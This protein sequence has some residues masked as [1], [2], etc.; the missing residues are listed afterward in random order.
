MAEPLRIALAGVGT[1]GAG[2]VRLLEENAATVRAR[3]GRDIQVVAISARDRSR[4]RGI[5]LSAFDWCDDMTAMAAPLALVDGV[6]EVE[7]GAKMIDLDLWC[8]DRQLWPTPRDY[9][10]FQQWFELR[11]FPLVEDL[12]GEPLR[13]FELEDGFDASV[14]DALR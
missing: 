5:D 10:M 3:A 13:S 4:D 8:R 6:V 9:A 12:G 2:V 14:R 11:F 7:A 1:V